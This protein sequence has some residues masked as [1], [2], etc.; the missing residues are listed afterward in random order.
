VDVIMVADPLP[1]MPSEV[2]SMAHGMGMSQPIAWFGNDDS[3]IAAS[4]AAAEGDFGAMVNRRSWEMPG[5]AV[6]ASNYVAAGFAN[7]PS[8]GKV[9]AYA[10]D[11]AKIILEAIDRANVTDTLVIRNEIAAT[12]DYNGVVGLYQ[13]FDANGDVVPQW[14]WIDTVDNGKWVPVQLLRDF[15]PGQDGTL[16]LGS[17]Y[18]QTTTLSIPAGTTTDTLVITYTQLPSVTTVGVPTLTLLSPF[19][20]RLE[21]SEELSSPMTLTVEYDDSDVVGIKEDTLSLYVR[22]GSAWVDADPCGGYDRDLV[23]NELEAVICHFSD[24]VLAGESERV[25]LP[26]VLRNNA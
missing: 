7:E 23:D 24:Y 1:E 12:A 9:T 4:P 18:G 22:E 15:D 25:Y 5:Y 6:F 11:A 3:Y 26:L 17:T 8:P 21:A 20:M 19:A 14:G 13:G 2:T 10:Y 16:D